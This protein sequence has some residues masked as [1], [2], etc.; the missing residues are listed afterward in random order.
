MP[1]EC[2]PAKE[3]PAESISIKG[4]SGLED[5]PQHHDCI[6]PGPVGKDTQISWAEHKAPDQI[7]NAKNMVE[8]LDVERGRAFVHYVG[9]HHGQLLICPCQEDKG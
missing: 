4:E 9:G 7:M 1:R 3:Q 2:T 5:S 6:S 8:L